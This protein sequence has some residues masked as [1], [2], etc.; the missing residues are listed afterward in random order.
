MFLLRAWLVI[1]IGLK[2]IGE[3]LNKGIGQQ[4][5]LCSIY[6][7]SEQEVIS[8]HGMQNFS[9]T[10]RKKSIGWGKKYFYY[11]IN[12]I[13]VGQKLQN[14]DPVLLIRFPLIS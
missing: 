7:V 13:W 2:K 1:E 9:F 3:K 11:V 8:E 10:T 12:E 14:S 5:L 6:Y 4:D